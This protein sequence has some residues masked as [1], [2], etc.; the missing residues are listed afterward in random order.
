MPFVQAKC[1]DCGGMLAVDDSKKAAVCQFCGE[2]FIVQ[3]AIN[4][5]ITNNIT[6]NNTTHNYGDGAVVNIYDDNSKDFDIEIGL[7]KKYHGASVDVI[8]PDSVVEIV[9]FCF[10]N[11]K[12]KSVI[13]PNSVKSIGDGAFEGCTNLKSVTIPNSVTSIGSSAF[14]RCKNLKS[15][16]IPNSVT[17]I[18][19][20][21]FSRCKNLK[22]VTIPDSV[23]SIGNEAFSGCTN[24]ASIN[25]DENNMFYSSFDGILFNE[26]KTVLINYPTGK[27]DIEY[28]IPDSVTNI[29]ERSFEEC[30]NLIS[31]NIPDSV[32]S[33]GD[34]AFYECTSLTSVTIPE[35]V[36]SIGGR[37]FYGCKNLMAIKMPYAYSVIGEAAFCNCKK[38]ITIIISENY[39]INSIQ[40]SFDEV[41]VSRI[42]KNRKSKQ[43]NEWRS[44][45]LCQYCGGEFKGIF[46]QKCRRCGKPKDY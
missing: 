15:V 19:S 5:Y 23:T 12:I 13:I 44:K 27:T 37:A 38:I 1:P 16:T 33:I 34:F 41:I 22:S 40:N 29:S 10:K 31:I 26:N 18:G 39:S 3:E 4:N 7:L 21:A 2:A 32:T 42:E 30:I 8:I 28:T 14:S 36:R 25:V 20:S 17:S 9:E 11:L 24:L 43:A 46:T 35:S 6:N 45:G